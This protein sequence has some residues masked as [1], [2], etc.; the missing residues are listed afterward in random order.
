MSTSA[1][2]S[3]LHAA[4]ARPI[5]HLAQAVRRAVASELI[6]LRTLRSQVWL[7]VTAFLFTLVMGPVQALGQVIADSQPAGPAD[8]EAAVAAAHSAAE[9]V[10]LALTGTSTATLLLGVTGVLLVAGEYLPRSVRTTF[11]L[12]PRRRLVVAAKAL[13]GGLVVAGT[14]V[15]AVAVAVSVT[16]ALLAHADVHAGWESPQVLRIAAATVWYLVGWVV[17]GQA[18]GWIARSKI[19]GSALLL[20][21]ML[22]L[23]PVLSLIPGRGGE[24]VVA[25]TPSSVGAAMVSPYDADALIGPGVGFGLWSAY[26]A[27]LMAIAAW[28]TV[29]RD[30]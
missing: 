8:D 24:V 20:L 29:K 25:L 6:K 17:L 22:V 1:T 15:V 14:S 13:A 5:P 19:G 7:L 16:L 27:G 9:A 23:S 11:M 28:L 26:L 10:M 4:P 30:A 3:T 2:N 18:A 12:V 21:V